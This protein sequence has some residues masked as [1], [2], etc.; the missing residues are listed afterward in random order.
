[1]RFPR[2]ES[3]HNILQYSCT[4]Y[5]RF[6]LFY[7]FPSISILI[8]ITNPQN[9][10]ILNVFHLFLYSDVIPT[11]INCKRAMQGE[12]SNLEKNNRPSK[13]K[14]KVEGRRIETMDYN[15]KY[16]PNVLK[17]YIYII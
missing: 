15:A 6:S 4:K 13:G 17:L 12:D 9:E 8:L 5:D 16:I 11:S 3:I 2:I 1:L 7:D 10:N 14:S